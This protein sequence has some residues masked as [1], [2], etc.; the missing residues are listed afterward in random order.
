MP[1]FVRD[2]VPVCYRTSPGAPDRTESTLYRLF[3]HGDSTEF[4][5]FHVDLKCFHLC[6]F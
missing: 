3:K 6:Q 4:V 2:T 5:R 1:V